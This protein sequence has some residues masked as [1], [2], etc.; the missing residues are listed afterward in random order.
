MATS[1]SPNIVTNGLVLALDAA[2]VRSY[3]GSGTSWFDLSGNGNTGT[4]VNGPTFNSGNGGSVVFDGVDDYADFGDNSTFNATLNAST[5]WSISYWVNPLTNG[6]VLDRGNIGADPTGALELNV[7]S[8]SRNNTSGGSSS[9]SVNIIGTGWNY[10]NVTRTSSLLLSWYLNGVF[11]NSSQLTQSYGGSG[12]WK[13]GRRAARTTSIYQGNIAQVS[14][15]NRALSAAEI[16][17]N[18]NATR[19]RFGV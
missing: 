18:F 14:I 5:N 3:P 4:L 1:Y 8:I 13:I 7:R 15:Y 10:V 12:I 16:S 9:L 2:N 19:N 17:Q 11:S 6:R